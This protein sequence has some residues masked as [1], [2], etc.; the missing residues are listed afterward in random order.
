MLI[1]QHSVELS[2]SFIVLIHVTLFHYLKML[3]KFNGKYLHIVCKVSCMSNRFIPVMSR[4][5]DFITVV[6]R[7]FV[8]A[9]LARNV[10]SIPR[11]KSSALMSLMRYRKKIDIEAADTILFDISISKRYFDIFDI[12]KHHYFRVITSQYTPEK[13]MEK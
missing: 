8:K 7:L 11:N 4:L 5:N 9:L 3:L 10:K 2:F 13:K 12:S 6:A 1:I